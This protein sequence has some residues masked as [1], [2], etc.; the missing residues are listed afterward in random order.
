L[1]EPQTRLR[2]LEPLDQAAGVASRLEDRILTPFGWIK[3]EL[4]LWWPVIDA[5]IE[6]KPGLEPR[7]VQIDMAQYL[8]ERFSRPLRAAGALRG[9]RTPP[10]LQN[11]HLLDALARGIENRLDL[12]E[13][14]QRLLAASPQAAAMLGGV[15]ECLEA[16][17]QGMRKHRLLDQALT[18]E[19]FAN[20]LLH[21]PRYR[22]R[23][24]TTTRVLVVEALDEATPLA[25]EVFQT[26]AASCTDVFY[27]LRTDGGQRRYLGADP[28]AARESLADR[29][30]VSAAAEGSSLVSI[31]RWIQA[32]LSGNPAPPPA[33]PSITYAERTTYLD[34]L[35]ALLDDVEQWLTG[36]A[37]LAPA[38]LVILAPSLEPVLLFCL[39]DRLAAL[40]HDLYVL[41]GSNRLV[42][43]PHAAALLALGTLATAPTDPLPRH[44]WLWILQLTT[45]LDPFALAA[46]ADSLSTAPELP[47]P[48][49]LPIAEAI[50]GYQ[51]LFTWVSTSRSNPPA[52]LGDLY[53]TAFAQVLRR[54]ALSKTPD[55]PGHPGSSG[56]PGEVALRELSQLAQVVDAAER[57][58]A[59]ADRLG[60]GGTLSERVARFGQFLWSGAIAERPFF[61]REPHRHSVVLATASQ[62]AQRGDRVAVQAWFDTSSSRWWKSDARELTNA[63]ALRRQRAPGPYTPDEDQRDMDAKLGGLLVACSARATREIRAY[64]ALVDAT[65]REQFGGLAEPLAELAMARFAT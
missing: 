62:F 57:F 47:E 25:L 17:R 49:A 32:S 59:I 3:R 27:G 52:T 53:G 30:I 18:W 14:S 56:L 11:I 15:P 43:Y 5:A 55:P 13:V 42:D 48:H 45:G 10:V 29:A 60:D 19:A 46:L 20:A 40:G 28:A 1:V 64:S 22:E 24:A 16:Y 2:W 58:T 4:E 9:A 36:S 41:S 8:M 63:Q 54:E 51:R 38:D 21:D 61:D 23:L 44:D 26:V 37:C 7:I 50:P 35:Q 12:A 31:G 33:N 65:G 6:G 39:R 34:M